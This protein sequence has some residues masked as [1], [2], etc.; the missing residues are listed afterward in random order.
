VPFNSSAEDF[1]RLVNL[2]GQPA[3][4]TTWHGP[5]TFYKH[6]NNKF[7]FDKYT[8]A[9]WSNGWNSARKKMQDSLVANPP[10][11]AAE[12][13]T[14][15]CEFFPCFCRSYRVESLVVN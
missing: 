4:F 5:K 3:F 15:D 7:W 14:V 6:P 9:S 10:A 11:E 12:E 2:M 8:E 13:E 1:P